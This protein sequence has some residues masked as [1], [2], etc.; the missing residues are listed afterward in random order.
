MISRSDIQIVG[1]HCRAGG[2]DP[3]VAGNGSFVFDFRPDVEDGFLVG[4]RDRGLY[5]GQLFLLR[6][7]KYPPSG[8]AVRD[9]E[10]GSLHVAGVQLRL[11]ERHERYA[12]VTD[13][14]VREFGVVNGKYA[15]VQMPG[16]V[17]HDSHAA[18]QRVPV[19][20]RRRGRFRQ[21][22]GGRRENRTD[23]FVL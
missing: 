2:L 15:L 22:D 6:F 11:F 10:V 5:V 23:Q 13:I 7:G 1:G 4:G 3:G 20:E 18:S 21:Y 19:V 14:V 9:Q 16:D 8:T 17:I 12:V